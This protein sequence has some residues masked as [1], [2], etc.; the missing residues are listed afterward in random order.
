[1]RP[2]ALVLLAQLGFYLIVYWTGPVDSRFYVLS[3]FPR[4]LFHLL[5]ATLALV[6]IAA[7][8]PREAAASRVA[9]FAPPPAPGESAS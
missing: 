1:M 6:A 2:A 7:L 3:T 4:L 9:P 5:P 8:G